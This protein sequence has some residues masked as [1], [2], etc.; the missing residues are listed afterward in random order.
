MDG[1]AEYRE[2]NHVAIVPVDRSVG[3]YG[4]QINKNAVIKW[5][6]PYSSDEITEEKRNQILQNVIEAMRFRKYT[7]E[8]V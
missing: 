5:N 1:Y 3:Q 6:P 7:V 2:G 8:L 4:S